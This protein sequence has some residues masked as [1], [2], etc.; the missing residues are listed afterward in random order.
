MCVFR[1]LLQLF[2]YMAVKN[3]MFFPLRNVAAAMAHSVKTASRFYDVHGIREKTQR[4]AGVA[5]LLRQ[6]ERF[7][8]EDV[9][10]PASSSD[11]SFDEGRRR[12]TAAGDSTAE[13][14]PTISR[15]A[16]A[17][18]SRVSSPTTS[19]RIPSPAA[20][21]PPLPRHSEPVAQSTP[22]DTASQPAITAPRPRAAR[23]RQAPVSPSSRV[24]WT[25][26]QTQFLLRSASD[27][28]HSERYNHR[29]LMAREN[30]KVI[31]EGK[32]GEQIYNKYKYLKKMMALGKISL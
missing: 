4:L 16:S 30:A 9:E 2:I 6:R 26:A 1:I 17:P 7:R 18:T 12:Q 23:Q 8:T 10:A 32:T 20:S 11:E 27:M 14:S 29:L 5:S 15:P 28:L 25:A 3:N 19:S 31:L 22:P 24:S 21:E 13:A